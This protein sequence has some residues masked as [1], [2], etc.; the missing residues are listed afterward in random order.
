GPS[1]IEN[2]DWNILFYNDNSKTKSPLF[3]LISRGIRDGINV[4]SYRKRA[5]ILIEIYK[6]PLEYPKE[7]FHLDCSC[8]EN[9]IVENLFRNYDSYHENKTCFNCKEEK[10][11]KCRTIVVNLPTAD[12]TFFTTF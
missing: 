12:L 5:M 1:W 3:E 6:P 7:H 11:R 10:T 8:T 4:Q 2:V 9:F